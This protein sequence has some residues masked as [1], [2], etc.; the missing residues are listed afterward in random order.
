MKTIREN[1]RFRII[2]DLFML[3]RYDFDR[4][5]D[6]YPEFRDVLTKMSSEKT[7]KLYAHVL[8]GVIL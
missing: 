7:D 1:S 6:V 8:D 5:K 4:I 2:W 3:G